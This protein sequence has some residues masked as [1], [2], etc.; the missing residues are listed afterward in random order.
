MKNQ[1]QQIEPYVRTAL[2]I[3]ALAAAMVLFAVLSLQAQTIAGG[4]VL[5]D[6][7]YEVYVTAIDQQGNEQWVRWQPWED[8]EFYNIRVEKNEVV[9]AMWISVCTG[10]T[11]GHAYFY[12]AP[13]RQK[14]YGHIVL[15]GGEFHIGNPYKL[16]DPASL[17]TN[18]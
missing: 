8:L 13:K 14:L 3:M 9:Q 16:N 18:Y 1:K 6:E 17:T 5:T 11:L 7:P 12:G 10:D 15:N 2:I 4:D